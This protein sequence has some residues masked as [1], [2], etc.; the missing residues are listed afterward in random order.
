MRKKHRPPHIYLDQ[1]YY[2]LTSGTF[3]K[4]A[5]IN[6]E[7]KKNLLKD[8]IIKTLHQYQYSLEAW[9]ILDNHYHM[10]CK[11]LLGKFLPKI[12]ATIHGKSAIEINKIDKKSGR[13]I[14]YQYWDYCI[15]NERDYWKHFNY[16]HS[17]PIKH[18]YV[19]TMKDLSTYQFSSFHY[20]LRKNG[21]GWIYDCF[22]RYPILDFTRDEDKF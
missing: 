5:Y 2:F 8:L 14:W 3:H 18:G 7:L 12:M 17:N 9:V 15:R 11:T 10:I 4:I 16:T 13:K 22:R 1:Q 6:N 20:W 21:E 19:N